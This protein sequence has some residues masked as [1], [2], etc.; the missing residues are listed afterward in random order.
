MKRH[1]KDVFYEDFLE[2]PTKDKLRELIK[3][4]F[5]E[6]DEFDF[7][8]TWI[9]KGKLAKL[10]LAMGNSRGRRISE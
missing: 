2:S 5:V 8:E 9:N 10:V 4:N 3:K 7:K 1:F 6:L